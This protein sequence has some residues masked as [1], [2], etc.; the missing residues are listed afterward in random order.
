MQNTQKSINMGQ[1]DGKE[2]LMSRSHS[3]GVPTTP[4]T[5]PN[6]S[7]TPAAIIIQL[8]SGSYEGRAIL[9]LALSCLWEERYMPLVCRLDTYHMQQFYIKVYINIFFL[10][11]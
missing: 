3:R 6:T 1:T 2:N 8:T 10:L 9:T 11:K 5:A 4:D 7:P